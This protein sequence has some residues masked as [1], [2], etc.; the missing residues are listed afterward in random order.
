[1]TISQVYEQNRRI[2]NKNRM[3]Q[4]RDRQLLSSIPQISQR[5]RVISYIG[6]RLIGA[7]LMA[8]PIGIGIARWLR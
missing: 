7:G 1:M 8:V 6:S 3:K 4:Y 2:L 5:D